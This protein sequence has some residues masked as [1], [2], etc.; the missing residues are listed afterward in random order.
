MRRTLPY[1]RPSAG[2]LR[3]PAR[4]IE[5][6]DEV[7]VLVVG[8]GPAGVGAAIAAARAGASTLLVERYGCLG[9]IWTAGLLNPYFDAR[10]KGGIATEIIERLRSHE[11]TAVED[12]DGVPYV[13]ANV[14]DYEAMKY[15]LD[16]MAQEA[17][18]RLLLYTTAVGAIVEDGAIRG[19]VFENKSG[20]S[21]VLAR[22][23]VDSSGDGDVAYHAGCEFELGRESD[24]LMQPMTLQFTVRG[25]TFEQSLDNPLYEVLLKYNSPDELAAVP[26]THPW[27]VP[28][29]GEPGAASVM[30]THLHGVDGTNTKDLTRAVIETRRQ[31]QDAMRLLRNAKDEIGDLHLTGTA[32]QV[33]VRETRRITGEYHLELEDL[34]AGR[35]FDDGICRVRFG[36]DIHEPDGKSGGGFVVQPYEIPFRCL[37]PL[38]VDNLLVAGRCI[39]GSHE[40]HAS[41]RVTGNCV[42]MGEAAGIGSVEALRKGVTPRELDGSEVRRIAREN[43]ANL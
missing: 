43:G 13:T 10:D 25:A 17:G 4:E 20:R 30:W 12:W 19:V 32:M 22:V 2:A 5:I 27:L 7:D 39:S 37:V 23:V 28:T 33:G 6:A 31:T 40:A 36:V 42:A 18:V 15:V 24:G 9:G 11:V 41:Y 21:A 8:G 14:F 34:K 38:S 35:T 16:T 1:D 29:A 26:Y 3:E